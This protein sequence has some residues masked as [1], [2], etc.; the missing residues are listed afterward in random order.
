MLKQ[1]GTFAILA[2]CL[3]ALVCA[4]VCP[5]VA[6][7]IWTSGK[8]AYSS[9]VYGDKDIVVMDPNGGHPAVWILAGSSDDEYDPTWAPDGRRLLYVRKL[10]PQPHIGDPTEGDAIYLRDGVGEHHIILRNAG[11]PTWAPTI[12]GPSEAPGI[13]IDTTES[14]IKVYQL[15]EIADV[16]GLQLRLQ[17]GNERAAWN[18]IFQDANIPARYHNRFGEVF[19]YIRNRGNRTLRVR[20]LYWDS[21]NDSWQTYPLSDIDTAN[22]PS[23]PAWS[24]DGRYIAYIGGGTW[25]KPWIGAS[26]Y[27]YDVVEETSTKIVQGLSGR[28]MSKPTWGRG[29]IF[30]AWEHPGFRNGAKALF[31]VRPDGS[32]LKIKYSWPGYALLHPTVAPYGGEF[33]MTRHHLNTGA[34]DLYKGTPWTHNWQEIGR[35]TYNDDADW[36]HAPD[37]AYSVEPGASQ[38]TTT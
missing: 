37:R 15:D 36:W 33:I 10:S 13:L 20:A 28:H 27:V 32:E 25:E 2:V 6:A 3:F 11:A 9:S 7:D 34:R 23:D 24:P 1:L 5:P 30:F 19:A 16:L 4:S 17:G 12:L 18:H 31:T 38:L 21:D 22:Q 29:E 35:D 26:L 8:V 14:G